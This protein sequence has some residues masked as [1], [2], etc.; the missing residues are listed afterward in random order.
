MSE[1]TSTPKLASVPAEEA[2][3][4]SVMLTQ[5]LPCTLTE[6]DFD[7][8]WCLEIFKAMKKAEFL[9]P[10]DVARVL[11]E[12]GI[13]DHVSIAQ[14]CARLANE[15]WPLMNAEYM[16]D[17]S[18]KVLGF[19]TEERRKWRLVQETMATFPTPRVEADQTPQEADTETEQTEVDPKYRGRM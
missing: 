15:H 17:A 13:F 9:T 16:V 2:T 10:Q 8:A 1:V 5:Y 18:V 3:I 19:W 7:D 4:A 6:D 14:D 12:D 11:Y